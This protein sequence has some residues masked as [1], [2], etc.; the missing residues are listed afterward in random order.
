MIFDV[1]PRNPNMSVLQS[2]L[3]NEAL[4]RIIL[5]LPCVHILLVICFK[6]HIKV[7]G[8]P[9]FLSD[10]SFIRNFSLRDSK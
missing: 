1:L 2:L 7:F 3:A 8:K 4:E 10:L 9:W 5:D 6:V